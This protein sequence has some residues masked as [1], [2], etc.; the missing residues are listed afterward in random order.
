MTMIYVKALR[1]A[2]DHARDGIA[3]PRVFDN[4]AVM[5]A[6]YAFERA[7]AD[8]S[9]SEIVNNP[10]VVAACAALIDA[11]VAVLFAR[12][13]AYAAEGSFFRMLYAHRVQGQLHPTRR[14]WPPAPMEN[15]HNG[16]LYQT[17]HRAHGPD[18]SGPP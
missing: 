6:H 7:C 15:A 5:G 18:K 13:K 4:D 1:D 9:H 10:R 11:E 17:G 8:A 14:R 2:F 12:A 3:E 16:W